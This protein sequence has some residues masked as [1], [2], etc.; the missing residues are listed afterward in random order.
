MS[1][2]K[3]LYAA[4]ADHINAA[5]DALEAAGTLARRAQPRRDH[6][7]AAARCFARRSGD[8]RSNGAGQAGWHEPARAGRS[9][10]GANW[11]NCPKWP[12]SRSRGRA[13]STCASR[14]RAWLAE[15]RVLASARP[16]LRPFHHRRR[17]YGQCRIC[18]GQS[19]RTDAHGPLPGRGGW[20][21]AGFAAR[22]RR[23]QG[24][25]RVLRQRR[26]RAGRCP[27]P[28]GASAV[29]RSARR[30]RRRDSRRAL[31]RRLSDP[32][33]AGTRQGIRRRL[34]QGPR[35][36]LARPVPHPR[37]GGDAGHDQG[38]SRAARHPARPV[39]LRGRTAGRRA[40]PKRPKSGCV[41]TIW[42]TTACSKRPRARCWKIGSRS[43]CRCSDRPNSATIRTG[44]SGKATAR[45]TYFGADLAYHFQKAEKRRRAGR[46][47]GRGPCR[48]GQADQGGGRGA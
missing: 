40:S 22:I 44:R 7:R 9:A 13:L 2:T 28:F 43:N 32:G 5:L 11:R 34:R 10:G 6:G 46:Y 36:R 18:L 20:R 41:P 42:S 16:R 23:A 39:F 8:Q 29:S 21:C 24:D 19:H 14:R 30:R 17:H 31:S 48:H 38:R 15:L 12:A 47:L 3:T 4:F 45:W 26:R 27:R 35:K 1:E 25:P 33:R 37:G